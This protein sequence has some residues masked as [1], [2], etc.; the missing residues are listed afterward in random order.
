MTVQMHDYAAQRSSD[1]WRMALVPHGGNGRVHLLDEQGSPLRSF[2]LAEFLPDF[3]RFAHWTTAGMAW[4]ANMLGY[5][6]REQR[7]FVVRAWWGAR[8]VIGLDG[9]RPVDPQTLSDELHG[10][11]CDIILRGLRQ[12]VADTENGEEPPY[13]SP[14]S[15]VICC[16]VGT[17]VHFPGLLALTEAIPLLH[18]L[19]ERLSSSGQCYSS[20][21]YY[22]HGRRQLAQ[23]SLRRLDEKPR[24]YPAL[25]FSEIEQRAP[26]RQPQPG[27]IDGQTRHT[28][29]A[30]IRKSTSLADVYL[31]LGAPDE[32]GRAF[33]RYDVD[34]AP[35]YTLV[36][37]LAKD[38]TVTRIVKYLPPFWAGPDIFPSRTHSLLGSDGRTVAA[39]LKEL[40]DG[41]FAGTRIEVDVL[42]ELE[43][44]GREPLVSLARA[45]LASEYDALGPLADA[46]EEANDSRATQVRAWSQCR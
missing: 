5:F 31:L 20:F 15:E 16:S 44:S 39:F 17:L 18:V 8:L 32:I 12:L 30:R 27:P 19:E 41:S 13:H 25:T 7:H 40:D 21:N 33:W 10:A 23:I 24:C 42:Q 1:G 14:S 9:L 6:T 29:L 38:D 43:F 37:W 45:V 22:M 28:S 26:L 2:D 35:P 3:S 46:L 34:A 4:S 11:E 36:L